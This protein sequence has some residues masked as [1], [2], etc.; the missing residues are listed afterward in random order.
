MSYRDV[1]NPSSSESIEPQ[2]GQITEPPEAASGKRGLGLK[3]L[4][5]LSACHRLIVRS[6]TEGELLQGVCGL[7]IELG[8]YGLAWIGTRAGT[9]RLTP[10]ASAAID[11]GY[12]TVY[13]LDS[14]L[15]CEH[16][17]AV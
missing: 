4:R 6:S 7:L 12:L 13:E 9:E 16:S 1:R 10:L 15:D 17:P 5:L 14:A 11:P 2:E 3:H 8:N